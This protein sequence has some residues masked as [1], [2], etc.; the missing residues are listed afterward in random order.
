MNCLHLRNV[1]NSAGI[2]NLISEFA[3]PQN[4]VR[5]KIYKN[6]IFTIFVF[7]ITSVRKC[8]NL[9]EHKVRNIVFQRYFRKYLCR[10]EWIS[11]FYNDV[12]RWHLFFA[13]QPVVSFQADFLLIMT[14]I[15][16]VGSYVQWNFIDADICSFC[17]G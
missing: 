5:L 17:Y 10:I 6:V 9:C 14:N 16:Y 8:L 2:R 12:T 4:Y 1:K 15:L 7:N 13:Y 11:L 3:L